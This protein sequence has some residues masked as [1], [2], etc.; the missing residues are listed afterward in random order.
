M[1]STPPNDLAGELH[2]VLKN[3]I[4][5]ASIDDLIRAVAVAKELYD[6]VN[7]QCKYGL[8]TVKAYKP[9]ERMR[10]EELGILFNSY[11]EVLNKSWPVQNLDLKNS[12]TAY[13]GTISLFLYARYF[14]TNY[15]ALKKEGFP[16]FMEGNCKKWWSDVIALKMLCVQARSDFVNAD[17]TCYLCK[18]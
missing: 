11:K 2:E 6:R 4:A 7:R 9:L 5:N 3:L 14:V 12:F 1:S 16:L 10:S 15:S 8:L 13:K 17:F 18:F